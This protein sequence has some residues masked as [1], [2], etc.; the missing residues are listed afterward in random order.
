MR[1][2]KIIKFIRVLR[3]IR[4][5]RQSNVKG[6]LVTW[7]TRLVVRYLGYCDYSFISAGLLRLLR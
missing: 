4:T 7:V 2:L 6:L 3:I 1:V 5:V